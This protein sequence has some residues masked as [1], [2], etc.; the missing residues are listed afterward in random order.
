MKVTVLSLASEHADTYVRLLHAMPDVELLI[1]DPDGPPDDQAR[2]RGVAGQLGVPYAGDW[3][4]VLEWRSNAVVV[5]SE[6]GRRRDAVERMAEA[7]AFVL[8]EQPLAVKS[9][10]VKAM[11]DTCD[12]AGVRLTLAS[13][14]CYGEAFAAVR[15]GIAD[16]VVGTLTTIHGSYH[17]P[18]A[19]GV[20]GGA[21]AANAPYLLDLVDVMLDGEPATR[22]Y[23]QAN[24][25]L[26]AA[27]GPESAAVLTV[28]YRS[29]VVASFTCGWSRSAAGGPALSLIGDKAS[30]EYDAAP[31]LLGGFDAVTGG[32]RREPGGE[33]PYPSMLRDFLGTIE[34]GAGNGPDGEAGL[35]TQRIVE[36]AY[37]SMHTGQPVD[38]N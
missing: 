14:A 38:L 27:A 19:A 9:S 37:E 22:V 23:A 20:N 11:V 21:L 7:E 18:P 15:R 5:T 34:T 31:R 36:A 13:P 16:G 1:A 35:R 6:V 28:S 26:G 24:G 32:E 4:E 8:C 10:D 29:G 33:D 3:D 17:T 12:M 25:V 2:A 30:L